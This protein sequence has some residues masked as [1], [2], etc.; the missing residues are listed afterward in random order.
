MPVNSKP[1]GGSRRREGALIEY[2]YRD[3]MYG[4]D[5]FS[6]AGGMSLGAEAAGVRVKVAVEADP[7]CRA[8]TQMCQAV[9]QAVASRLSPVG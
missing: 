6:G 1:K 5:L 7:R 2:H 3:V 8:L 9:V 4:I